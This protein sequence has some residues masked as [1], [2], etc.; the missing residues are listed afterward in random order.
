MK[1]EDSEWI[2]MRARFGWSSLATF[3]SYRVVFGSVRALNHRVPFLLCLRVRSFV[4]VGFY[5]WNGFSAEPYTNV[6]KAVFVDVKAFAR[7]G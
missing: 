7:K 6:I 5:G 2:M 1:L 4:F 3:H